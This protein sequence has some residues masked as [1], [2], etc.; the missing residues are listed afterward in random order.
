MAIEISCG[1]ILYRR[2]NGSIEYLIIKDRNNNYSFP[3]GHLN[4]NETKEECAIREIEEEVG[5][6]VVLDKN[7]I[8]KITYPLN[9]GNTKIVYYYLASF[10]GLDPFINDGEVKEIKIIDFNKALEII[11]YK[12]LK[13]VLLETRSYMHV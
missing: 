3:K 13:D 10:D 5:L 11:T 8:K 2:N 7:F 12:Q 4:K 9:N 1:A 6:K